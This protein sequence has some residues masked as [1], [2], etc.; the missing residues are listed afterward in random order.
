[1]NVH[2]SLATV[3]D[4]QTTYRALHRPSTQVVGYL[5]PFM[6]SCH[7]WYPESHKVIQPVNS[8]VDPVELDMHVEHLQSLKSAS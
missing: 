8:W 6:V 2:R 5:Y 7:S 1:M 3:Q 4:K